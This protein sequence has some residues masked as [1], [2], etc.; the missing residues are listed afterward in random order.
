MPNLY[1]DIPAPQQS[2]F[3]KH[4]PTANTWLP[5][6]SVAAANL[7]IP[8]AARTIGLMCMVGN[9]LHLYRDGTADGNLVPVVQTSGI[10]SGLSGDV[11]ATGTGIV[12]ATLATVN[13]NVG[14][15]SNANITV[16]GKGRITAAANGSG[17]GILG[18]GTIDS[19][20][21]QGN[22]AGING[23]NLILQNADQ[24]FP[25]LVS[26]GNQIFEGQKN[27]SNG[28]ITF[29]SIRGGG[30]Y[31]ELES[32]GA[33]DLHLNR[34]ASGLVIIKNGAATFTSTEITLG[35]TLIN[36][37]LSVL[38]SSSFWM[39][40]PSQGKGKFNIGTEGT[41][42]LNDKGGAAPANESTAI[43]NFVSETRGL[44]IPRMTSAQRI[45]IAYP[46]EG[47]IVIQTDN[48]KGMYLFIDAVWKLVTAV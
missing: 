8:S 13:G 30:S 41:G 21:K 11:T 22:G 3:L 43:F 39:D 19:Q 32:Q 16:D 33:K 37:N 12:P 28:G 48:V 31:F 4:D 5:Y 47:L 26:T 36:G 20:T 25:G 17:G 1:N 14:S 9:V 40:N 35:K 38:G 46:A 27:F 29:G 23:S 34:S 18:I 24:N 6:A 44:L 15:F 7:A 45:A 10:I 42:H 2:Y